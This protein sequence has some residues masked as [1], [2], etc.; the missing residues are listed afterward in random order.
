[1]VKPSSCLMVFA[2]FCLALQLPAYGQAQ[3]Y[4]TK[5]VRYVV[6][7]SPGSGGDVF[8]RIIAAGLTEVFGQQVIVDNRA[9]AAS[10]IGAEIAAK[11]VPD[12]YTLLAVSSTLSANISLYRN[13]QYDLVRDLAPV[14]QMGFT[15]FVLV[16]HPSTPLKTIADLIKLAKAK[17]GAI[18]YSSAGTGTATFIAGELFKGVAG[19]DIVHVP[20]K[21]G[22]PALMAVLSGEAQVYF[23]PLITSLSHIRQG[24]VHALATMSARRFPLFPA[25]P[26]LAE[27]GVPGVEFSNSFGMM[28]PAKTPA[29]TIATLHRAVVTVLG[30][31]DVVR[32]INELGCVVIGSQPNEYAAYVR[33]EIATLAEMFRKLG[34]AA[35]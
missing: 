28:V 12:G 11:A 27:A 32:R 16:V 15:P 9:G 17:P 5:T 23:A 2:V 29:G 25:L 34:I 22:G 20:Y 1:M 3:N 8:G 31:P 26:T 13:L 21:G 4:P 14:T 33:K 35:E 30:K 19:V 24:T 7:D 6:P 10:N 18:N